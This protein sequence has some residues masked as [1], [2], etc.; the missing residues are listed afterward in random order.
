MRRDTVIGVIRRVTRSHEFVC[1]LIRT[2][3]NVSDP[4][5][6]PPRMSCNYFFLGRDG[7]DVP[8]FMYEN[9]FLVEKKERKIGYFVMFIFL[10]MEHTSKTA[11]W[12]TRLERYQNEVFQQREIRIEDDTFVD[13]DI[14]FQ[15]QSEEEHRHIHPG[16][17][18]ET[19][20]SLSKR[21]PGQAGRAAFCNS[22]IK[23]FSWQ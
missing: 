17:T 6:G 21:Y 15:L 13:V 5:E 19:D 16:H 9:P 7:T 18:P 20:H 10:R 4:V 8:V 1:A 22:Q 14:C 3:E 23:V 2:L 12:H 11:T